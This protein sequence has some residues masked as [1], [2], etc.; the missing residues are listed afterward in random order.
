MVAAMTSELHVAWRDYR[1]RRRLL[2]AILVLVPVVAAAGLSLGAVRA[3]LDARHLLLA[4][5]ATCL[6]AALF[7]FADFRCPYCSRHFH[8]TWIDAN[9][10]SD[11]CLHCGFEKWRDPHAARIYGGR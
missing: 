4:A 2:V 8:W 1:N 5:W 6:V 7:R 9:P 10:L 3:V 11:E